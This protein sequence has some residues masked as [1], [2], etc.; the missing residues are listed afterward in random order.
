MRIAFALLAL[1]SAFFAPPYLTLILM[2][3][4]SLRYAAWEVI[5]IGFLVDCLWFTPVGAENFLGFV[6]LFTAAGLFLVWGLEPLRKEFL[7]P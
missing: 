7:V 3:V 2:A 5:L 4:L 1:L 6:P